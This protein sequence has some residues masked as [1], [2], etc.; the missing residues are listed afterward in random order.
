MH[1]SGIFCDLAKAFDCIRHKILLTGI[2]GATAIW[3]RCYLTDRK[4]KSE[5]KSQNLIQRTNSNW[6]K[7]K[8]GVP[9]GQF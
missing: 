4:Q 7:I 8:H 5:I 1:V 9:R 3:F 2:Q 6:V